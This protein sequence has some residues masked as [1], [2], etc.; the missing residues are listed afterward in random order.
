MT[1]DAQ[2][3]Q[4]PMADP[5][6]IGTT[7]AAKLVGCHRDTLQEWARDGQLSPEH[8]GKEGRQR[9]YFWGPA[10]IAAAQHLSNR[11]AMTSR[12][13]VEMLGGIVPHL[14]QAR[15]RADT[16]FPGEHPT[17]S[18]ARGVRV[19]RYD[20]TIEEIF[21]LHGKGGVIVIVPPTPAEVGQV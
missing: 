2:T 20:Q 11:S 14:T 9:R 21:K 13:S 6:T 5:D 10:D 12:E 1:T 8:N 7:D 4:L 3:A 16:G 19:L 15:V 17:I 18:A